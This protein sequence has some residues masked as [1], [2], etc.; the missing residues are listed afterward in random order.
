MPRFA[1]GCTIGGMNQPP[2]QDNTKKQVRNI[3]A[4]IAAILCLAI[5]KICASFIIPIVV[6][7]FI[8]VLVGVGAAAGAAR[9]VRGR[10]R[11][12]AFDLRED[13]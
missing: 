4:V 13:A 7:F 10:T 6:A 8:F 2:I 3:L 12:T 1:I 11:R 9:Y 5:L